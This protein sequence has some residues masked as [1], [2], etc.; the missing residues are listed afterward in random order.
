MSLNTNRD[1]SVLSSIMQCTLESTMPLATR[2]P[3]GLRKLLK[4]NTNDRSGCVDPGFGP[5]FCKRFGCRSAVAL[6]F[7][8]A[9][10]RYDLHT[11]GPKVSI[12]YI[13]EP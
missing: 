3:P 5:V 9:Q 1:V 10:S 12:I 11:S 2:L 7:Q 6:G 13:L 8:T 4:P